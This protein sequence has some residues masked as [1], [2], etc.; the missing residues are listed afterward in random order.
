MDAKDAKILIVDDARFARNMVKRALQKGGYANFAEADSAKAALQ[1]FSQQPPDLVLL[2][3]TLTDRNDLS[4][5]QE[6][7][8]MDPAAKVVM[9]SAIGQDLIIADAL[10]LGA[11]DFITK[12]FDEEALLSIVASVLEG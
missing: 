12:P 7:L 8:T 9:N 4:L 10:E 11:K 5:L 6:L 1:S 3:I 2:D